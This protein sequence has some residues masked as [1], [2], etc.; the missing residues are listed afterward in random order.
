MTVGLDRSARPGCSD[1]ETT[2]CK[3]WLSADH[4]E[5]LNQRLLAR[6]ANLIA[7]LIVHSLISLGASHLLLL[8]VRVY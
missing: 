1:H 7:N 5:L 6:L 8:H 3:T 4:N 2:H